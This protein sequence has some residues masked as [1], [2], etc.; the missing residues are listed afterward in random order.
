MVQQKLGGPPHKE[1]LSVA[2]GN[3]E[4]VFWSGAAGLPTSVATNWQADLRV[5]MEDAGVWIKGNLSH[6]FRDTVVDF[7][8]GAW[9]LN[10]RDRGHAGGYRGY[11]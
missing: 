7:W 2:N 6:R 11:R 1:L 4:F 8:L 9:L 3:P 10:D 5:L